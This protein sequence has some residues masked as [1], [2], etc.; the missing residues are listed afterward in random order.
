MTPSIFVASSRLEVAAHLTLMLQFTLLLEGF[1]FL[2]NTIYVL[3]N[4]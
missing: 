3:S 1:G 4:V 2:L